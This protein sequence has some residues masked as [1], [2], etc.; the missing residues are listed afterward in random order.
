M[1][2]AAKKRGAKRRNPGE[3]GLAVAGGIAAGVAGAAAS[4]VL[5][6]VARKNPAPRRKFTSDGK[7]YP[8]FADA[9]ANKRKTATSTLFHAI[10]REAGRAL[11]GKVKFSSVI[12]DEYDAIAEPT[13][14]GC[15]AKLGLEVHASKLETLEAMTRKNPSKRRS[16]AA[17]P[18]P[19][20][21]ERA[22]GAPIV[23][24]TPDL[25][26]FVVLERLTMVLADG[27]RVRFN[28]STTQAE[29]LTPSI[30]RIRWVPL[31]RAGKW[32]KDVRRV[33]KGKAGVYCIRKKGAAKTLYVGEGGK[34]RSGQGHSK[35]PD[36]L[37]RTILR[38]FQA[39]FHPED[40]AEGYRQSAKNA[41]RTRRKVAG[42]DAYL[43]GWGRGQRYAKGGGKE[44]VFHGREDLDV[45]LYVTEPKEA[46]HHEGR[47]IMELQPLEQ[48]ERFIADDDRDAL[49][50]GEGDASFDTASM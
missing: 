16:A 50:T 36:R 6:R 14:P 7:G 49:Y 12:D 18:N 25:G 11:C 22:D 8:V 41:R 46:Y 13:C 4:A 19:I 31:R 3:L 17:R 38:H 45:A 21:V 47:F 35:D 39:G 43:G 44:W 28:K 34:S 27:R 26:G 2:M 10:D 40:Y 37:M 48:G 24:L 20:V 30:N 23:H 32:N 15:R 9:Y 33:L 29:L 42:Q 1:I 5:S